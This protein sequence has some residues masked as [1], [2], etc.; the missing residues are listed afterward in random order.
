M[1]S[2]GQARTQHGGF[3]I[4]SSSPVEELVTFPLS[5]SEQ[6]LWF[7]D[8]LQPGTFVNNVPEAWRLKGSLITDLFERSIQ[9]ITRRHEILRTT[10]AE[11]DG[12]PVQVV[13]PSLGPCLAIHDL[14]HLPADE[15]GR[16]HSAA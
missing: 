16:R 7:L 10:F 14:T 8:R 9:E 3:V 11:R 15:R 2:E 12:E 13:L 4:A 5:F 6:R 1:N